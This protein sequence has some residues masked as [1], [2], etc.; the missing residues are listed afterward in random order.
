MELLSSSILRM[1]ASWVDYLIIAIVLRLRARHRAHAPERSVSEQHRLLP[2]RPLAAGLGDRPGVHLAPT[3]AP[4]RSWA[5]RPTAPQFGMP[6]VHYFWIGAIPA[7]LFLGVVMMPFYY[8]SKVRS[9]PEFMLPPVRHRRPPGQRHQLRARPAADRRR[10]PLPARRRIVNALLGWPLWVS[11]IVAAVIVLSYI[12]LG[13]LSAAIYNEVLQFFVIVAAL[14]PLTLLG[15]HRVGGW[16]G[17]KDKI[18]AASADGD[19]RP[20]ATPGRATTLTGFDSSRSGR[21]SASSSGSASCCPS[22][23]GRRTSS[24]CSGR[25]PPDSISAA[26]KTPIIG[27][28]PKMF[29]PFIIDHPRHDRR[30]PR[31][32]DRVDQEVRSSGR[33]ADGVTYNDSLLL[34]DA[35]TCCPTACSAWRSP[36]CWRRSWPAWR[37]TSRRSTRC[38]ATTSGRPTSSR[39]S[40][41]DYYLTVGRLATVAATVIAIGTA[42]CRQPVPEHHGLPADP[43]RVLQR[44]AVRDVHPRHV[45]EADDRDR[46]LGRAWCRAPWPPSSSRSCQPGRV[47][48]GEHRRICTSVARAPASPPPAQ[49]SWWT[50]WS[51]WASRS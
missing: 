44:A 47:R 9:V 51:A 31:Q 43:V 7:M 10:Q 25:W 33:R 13:G 27:A 11:L 2:L 12:T 22:A 48:V 50:S 5:C 26:R 20:A 24:R 15:L 34:S 36:A 37:P 41:D 23:T 38:S 32:P 17:L 18:T 3:S 35:A 49:R 46:G 30:R 8:G 42:Y 19:Q 39:T 29:I 16:N 1:D 14:L 6:T 45:L 21:W 40:R 28:F 4:S